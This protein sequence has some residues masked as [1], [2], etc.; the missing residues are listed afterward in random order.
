MFYVSFFFFC[1][2]HQL[3]RQPQNKKMWILIQGIWAALVEFSNHS[4]QHDAKKHSRCCSEYHGSMLEI[5]MKWI[6]DDV[7][8]CLVAG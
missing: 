1:I 6:D 7:I 8:H 4:S 5:H 3:A 2:P